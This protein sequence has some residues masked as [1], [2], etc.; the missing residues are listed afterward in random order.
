MQKVITDFGDWASN[1]ELA[2][3]SNKCGVLHLGSKNKKTVHKLNGITL[4][5][6]AVKDL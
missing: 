2:L 6:N 5:M 3:T 4:E 1:M